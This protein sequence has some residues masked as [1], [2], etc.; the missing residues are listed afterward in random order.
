[1][2]DRMYEMGRK[3]SIGFREIKHQFIRHDAGLGEWDYLVDGR[4]LNP[5]GV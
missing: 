2:L 3:C 4:G 1:M 5:V